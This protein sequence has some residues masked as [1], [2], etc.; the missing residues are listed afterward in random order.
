ML[1]MLRTTFLLIALF[2]M[3]PRCCFAADDGIVIHEWGT[4]TSLQDETGRTIAGINSDDEPVPPFVH[5]LALG[6]L[7]G[8]AAAQSRNFLYQ[9]WPRAHPDVKM[10]LETPVLYVHAGA[11]SR[12]VKLDVAVEF[13]G[14][15]L[16]QFYPDA[17]AVGPQPGK[18]RIDTETRGRLRWKDMALRDDG[19]RGPDT[20]WHV[21]TTPRKVSATPLMT[22]KGEIEKYLFYRGV[23]H[24]DSPMRV[25]RKGKAGEAVIFQ[26][27]RSA[28]MLR[29]P[30]TLP[31]LWMAD[32]R[33]DGTAAF[34]AF[35]PIQPSSPLAKP[36]THAIAFEPGA[37]S[38]DN[39]SKLR[40]SMKEAL[41]A[42]GLFADE[43]EAMLETWKLSY[44]KSWGT[45]V[46]FIVPRAW[47]ESVLPLQVTPTPKE[48]RRVMV[49]RIDLV[50]PRHRELLAKLTSATDLKKQDA[51]LWKVYD[52][53]G[54]FRNALV[55][56]ELTRQ[57]SAALKQFIANHGLEA[58]AGN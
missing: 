34:Q 53:L 29:E 6:L 3:T 17:E 57:D 55:L 25:I 2:V 8:D 7:V 35:G 5:N 52:Q 1:L 38:A 23:G 15:W 10:R 56:D 54:R 40:A 9:G 26:D 43:A 12:D 58:A 32:F 4:F 50:T 24:V 49:G 48:I 14:G 44:F 13:R 19:A 42:D 27:N 11:D 28:D 46:F 18:I 33:D 41:I 47:T 37:Y 39:V 21:W 36:R 45:R 22:P 30:M 31:G 16:T 20:D 51:E